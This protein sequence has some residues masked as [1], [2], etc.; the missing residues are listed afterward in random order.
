LAIRL[1]RKNF[2]SPS[3][4]IG[5]LLG[6]KIVGQIKS[7]VMDENSWIGVA[8]IHLKAKE[9]LIESGLET[10]NQ[11]MGRVFSL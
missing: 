2:S 4:P 5:I 10:E 1:E 3:L 6:D 7:L 11:G 8:K 9:K